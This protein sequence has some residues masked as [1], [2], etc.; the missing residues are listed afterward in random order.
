MQN[1]LREQRMMSL[2]LINDFGKYNP[3]QKNIKVKLT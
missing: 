3:K 1:K 2:D